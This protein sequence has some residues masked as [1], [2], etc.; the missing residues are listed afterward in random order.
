MAKKLQ[1]TT[2]NDCELNVNTGFKKEPSE[3]TVSLFSDTSTTEE[4]RKDM[5]LGLPV[6]MGALLAVLMSFPRT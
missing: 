2:N 1:L 5:L 6:T 3:A 4:P